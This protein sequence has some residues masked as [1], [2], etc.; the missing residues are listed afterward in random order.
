MNDNSLDSLWAEA[1]QHNAAQ[2]KITA[3]SKKAAPPASGRERYTLPEFWLPGRG[4][5]L[6]HRETQSLIGN[7]QEY[8]H[9]T[10]KGARKLIKVDTPIE[11]QVKEYISGWEHL[12]EAKEHLLEAQVWEVER[13]VLMDLALERLG[14]FAAAVALKVCL[15]FGSIVRVGLCDHQTFSSL[16]GHTIL[17]LPRGTNC[18]EV[19]GLDAKIALRAEL[20]VNQ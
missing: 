4:I 12:G 13:E 19:M 17:T 9:R 11:I 14:V 18:L 8:L 20:Q 7:Y 10:E 2:E 3:R 15:R 6:I 1:R 16:D 5:A